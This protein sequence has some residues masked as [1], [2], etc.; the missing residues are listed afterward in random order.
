[1]PVARHAHRTMTNAFFISDPGSSLGVPWVGLMP[2]LHEQERLL[3]CRRAGDFSRL[4]PRVKNQ[5]KDDR[6]GQPKSA[7]RIGPSRMSAQQSCVVFQ[8]FIPRASL[9][10]SRNFASSFSDSPG[11][12]NEPLEISTRLH[13]VQ[14]TRAVPRGRPF[15][16]LY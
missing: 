12:R 7:S 2:L 15:S 3:L 8:L 9:F 5:T 16:S 6:Q 14:S 10:H 4:T 13:L 11:R 1:M